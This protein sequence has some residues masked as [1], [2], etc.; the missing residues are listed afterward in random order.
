MNEKALEGIVVLDLSQFLSGPRCTQLLAMKGATVIKIEPPAGEAMRVLCTLMNAERIMSTMHQNKKG[1]VLDL[2]KEEG[3]DIFRQLVRKADV[4]VENFAP[5]LMDEMGLG[6]DSLKELNPRIVYAV[7]SGF[8]RTG[9]FSDRLAFDIISQAAGGIMHAYNA[10]HCPPK[11]FFGDLVSGAYC[12][13]GIMEALLQRERTGRGQLVDVS[14]QDVMYFQHFGAFSDKAIEPVKEKVTELLGRDLNNLLTDESNPL[15]FWNSYR[16]TDGY[17][18]LVALTERQWRNFMDAIGR[19]EM[20]TNPR[21]S[22]FAARVRNASE[23]TKIIAEWAALH[24]VQEVFNILT[25]VRIPCQPVLD[26]S[27]VNSDPQLESRGM[28]RTVNHS[29]LG[30][31]A[32]PGD[33]VRLSESESCVDKACP[34]LGQHTDEV[35]RLMLGLDDA[36]I[37][38]LKKKR[39]I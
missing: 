38:E 17:I 34:D 11:I 23:G 15:P 8:G 32:V 3:K 18:V 22:N 4:V 10:P 35:L 20:K 39:A 2:K 16:A 30:D 1:I 7:I 27:Q 12:A 33:P 26:K 9:P 28:L 19:P 36:A 25:A 29:R 13:L 21:F 31:I 37:S 24:T 5:G 6:Y 14:M